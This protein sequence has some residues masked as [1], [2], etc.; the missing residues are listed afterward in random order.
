MIFECEAV[1]WVGLASFGASTGVLVS[2]GRRQGRRQGRHLKTR[3]CSKD[4][5]EV[6]RWAGQRPV[7][8]GVAEGCDQTDAEEESQIEGDETAQGED[9]VVVEPATGARLGGGSTTAG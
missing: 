2:P 9:N 6:L 1:P 8:L 3:A 5:V 4:K 7:S